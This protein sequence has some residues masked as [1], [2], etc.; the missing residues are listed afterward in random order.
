M[1]SGCVLLLGCCVSLLLA[2]GARGDTPANCSYEDLLG[3]WVFQ[4]ST[5]GHDRS[6]NCS[7]EGR[8]EQVFILVDQWPDFAPSA[9]TVPLFRLA[10]TIEDV[11]PKQGFKAV[12]K[13]DSSSWLRVA[14]LLNL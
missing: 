12:L 14:G 13:C 8:S 7:T 9:L 10:R 3:T 6:V 1:K 4:V 11:P 2:G 5:G